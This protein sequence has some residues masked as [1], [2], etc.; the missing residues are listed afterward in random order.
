MTPA[1][2]KRQAESLLKA[3]VGDGSALV[4]AFRAAL[5]GECPQLCPPGG[6]PAADIQADQAPPRPTPRAAESPES[7]GVYAGVCG[8]TRR[9]CD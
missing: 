9:R 1:L 5:I 8:G 3:Q 4:R 7:G 6:A 2:S